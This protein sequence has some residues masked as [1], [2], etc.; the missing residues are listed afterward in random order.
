MVG[1]ASFLSHGF[2]HH[3]FPQTQNLISHNYN[4]KLKVIKC[5]LTKQGNRFLTSISSST[6][7][8]SIDPSPTHRLIHKF[9]STSSKS[10]SLTTLNHLISPR[11]AHSRLF[12]IVLP[13]SHF[14]YFQL[15]DV[16]ILCQFSILISQ[17]LSFGIKALSLLL[18]L[19]S[20]S[21]I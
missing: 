4:P 15:H 21:R 10:V 18:L 17:F 19:M 12:F 16:L 14:Y 9:V 8:Y 7:S 11:S 2:V 3:N 1:S 13:V 5:A 6:L 20:Q